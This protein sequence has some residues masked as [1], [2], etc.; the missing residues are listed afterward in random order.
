MDSMRVTIPAKRSA[1]GIA[2]ASIGILFLSLVIISCGGGGE[3]NGGN[4]GS[5]IFSPVVFMADKNVAGTVELFASSNDGA[6]IIKLS[7]N[8]V[9]GG[10]V[11]AFK[12]S[13]DGIFAAYV[14]DQSRDQVFELY[15]VPVDG[16]QS[17]VKISG[18]FMA[19]ERHIEK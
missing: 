16:G 2:A 10:D 6:D 15:V 12:I 14:A 11:V 7:G 13:P 9:S 5:P 19:G 8:M 1:S 18:F 3:D 17:A 4:P